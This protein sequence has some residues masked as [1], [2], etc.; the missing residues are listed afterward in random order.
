M[1]RTEKQKV[2][3][4]FVVCLLIMVGYWFFFPGRNDVSDIRNGAD[5]VRNGIESAEEEQRDQAAALDRATDAADRSQQAVRD[6]QESAGRI[7]DIE[8]SDA[9]IIGECQSI[10]TAIRSRGKTESQSQN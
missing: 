4:C 2:A 9:E 1:D 3:I 8:R 7:E 10:L 6:S 5:A